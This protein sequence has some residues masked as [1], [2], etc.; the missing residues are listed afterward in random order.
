MGFRIYSLELLVYVGFGV[1]VCLSLLFH[2]PFIGISMLL[3]FFVGLFR[4]KRELAAKR[5]DA[6]SLSCMLSKRSQSSTFLLDFFFPFLYQF[7]SK[8]L[9]ILFFYI[10]LIKNYKDIDFFIISLK[11]Q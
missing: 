2:N 7:S 9:E 8:T 6:L 10:W 11:Q 5:E 3:G 4:A 1:T